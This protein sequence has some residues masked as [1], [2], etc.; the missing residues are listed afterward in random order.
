[1]TRAYERLLLDLHRKLD[2]GQG[3]GEEAE[4]VREEPPPEIQRGLDLLSS[5][6]P[7]DRLVW[8]QDSTVD[9]EALL[10]IL[11]SPLDTG[12]SKE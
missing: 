9:G 5:M 2:A 3:S 8:A 10:S 1:M 4:A 6:S 11:A 7:E 12:P